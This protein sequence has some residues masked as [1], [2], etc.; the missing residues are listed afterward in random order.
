MKYINDSFARY[1]SSIIEVDSESLERRIDV[2]EMSLEQKVRVLLAKRMLPGMTIKEDIVI[3]TKPLLSE[4]DININ[5]KSLGEV[6]GWE[7]KKVIAP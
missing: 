1:V 2:S 3:I 6:L 5:L 7:Y 4:I